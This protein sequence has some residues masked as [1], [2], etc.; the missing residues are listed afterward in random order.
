MKPLFLSISSSRNAGGLYNCVMQLGQSLMK[1]Q[2]VKPKVLAFE[3]EFSKVDDIAY[4]LL[5]LEHYHIVGPVGVG[6]TMDLKEKLVNSGTDLVHQHGIW[7][8]TSLV[9]K[10]FT[11]RYKI[12]YL[13]SPH[14]MLDSWIL[15]RNSW[16]K[17]IALTVYEEKNIRGAACLHA[18]NISEY[19]SIRAAGFTNPVAIVPN[20]V[21]LPTSREDA[22]DA[23]PSWKQKGKKTILFLSRLHP[24]KG[25]ENLLKAWSNLP[26]DLKSQW[27][28]II[29]GDSS[30]PDYRNSLITLRDNLKLEGQVDFIGP[31]F[32]DDK[33]ICFNLADAFI[34][35]SFSEGMPL[36]VLEAWSYKLPTLIT[37][38]CNLP[39]GFSSDAS[40][41]IE[42]NVNSIE[43][44][45]IK[46]IEM[47]DSER[48]LMG[49]RAYSIVKQKYTW[50]SVAAEMKNV[51]SWILKQGPLP[52][53]IKFD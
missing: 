26:D 34:L 23:A 30:G 45:L 16:K 15:K 3:D 42:P 9:R 50:D 48:R 43:L 1:M 38:E 27:K 35:P 25:L 46:L 44:G 8:Y 36:A 32:H 53:T 21:N 2:D 39:D 24:K 10:S 18:L 31:Q 6:F 17:K 37:P 14:G 51:Y 20:G 4:G 40:I 41:Y 12:P 29:A 19:E 52:S 22:T 13:I 33:D 7:L 28:I 11:D 5:P 49:E 47:S